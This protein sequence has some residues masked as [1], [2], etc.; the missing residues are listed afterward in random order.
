MALSCDYCREAIEGRY[1]RYG[2]GT[3][4]CVSCKSRLRACGLCGKPMTSRG[5]VCA[6]C[7]VNA[8]RCT[9][10]SG[11]ITGKYW[12]FE[13]AGVFCARCHD[14]APRCARCGA[15]AVNPHKVA[16]RGAEVVCGRC[17]DEADRCAACE[18]VLTASY[19]T[20]GVDSTRKYCA[21][22]GE[23]GERCDFCG[24]PV[25]KGGHRYGDGRASCVACRATAVVDRRALL[26]LEREARAWLQ[27]R[28]G[29]R[30]RP[31]SECP[32][33]LVSAKQLAKLQQKRFEATP[34][35]DM[36]ERGLFQASVTRRLQGDQEVGR[37]EVLAIYVEDGLPLAEAY[38]TMVHELAHLWQ[39]DHFPEGDVDL[40]YVEGLACWVQYQA[41][42]DG[43]FTAAAARVE[44]RTDAVYGAGFRLVSDIER[45]VGAHRT[46]DEVVARVS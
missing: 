18:V 42:R 33:E 8:K 22:C 29:L 34:G 45:R 19:S 30:L 40:R 46:L 37:T 43:G 6:A 36:R 4:C 2:D 21:N 14:T 7:A 23:R 44:G 16:E 26:D 10:C 9:L 28:F 13:S 1:V 31:A 20:F 39:H 17:W 5:E 27:R 11:V 15:P 25:G 24:A 32:V 35:F 41:L 12:S 3:V 38:G